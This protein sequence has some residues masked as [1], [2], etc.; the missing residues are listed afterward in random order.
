MRIYLPLMA[1]ALAVVGIFALLIA[2]NEY[3]YQFMLLSSPS[4][5]TVAITLATF[6]DNERY[7][8]ELSRWRPR[9]SMRC[10]RSRCSLRSAATSRR[11]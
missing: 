1:P 9:S 5:K 2:W 10:R 4:N 6:F 8:V 11:G 3:L 7:A